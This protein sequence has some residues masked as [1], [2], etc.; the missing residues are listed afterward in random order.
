MVPCIEFFCN[1]GYGAPIAERLPH[2]AAGCRSQG[3]AFRHSHPEGCLQC[4][5]QGL[6]H[7]RGGH[8]LHFGLRGRAPSFPHNSAPLL[9]FTLQKLGLDSSLHL[10]KVK[11][12]CLNMG[13]CSL[14]C[15]WES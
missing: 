14:A 1:A 11:V 7:K 12:A 4:S 10:T 2:E 13:V 6:G 15:F 8:A 3:R 9:L 5:Y